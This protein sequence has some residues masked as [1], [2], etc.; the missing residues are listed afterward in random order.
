M[1]LD[2]AV[3][4]ASGGDPLLLYKIL[5]LLFFPL[6]RILCAL[7]LESR[8]NYQ[9][10]LD[11]GPLEFQFL[12]P[13][14]CLINPFRTLSLCFGVIDKTPG[15]TSSNNFV[16]KNFVCIGHHNNILA[17]C[18][19]IFPLLRWQGVWNKTCTQPSLSKSEE[20]LTWGSSKILLTF[21]MR[22]DGH[23]WKKSAT[24]TMFTSVLLNFGWATL[25]SSSTSSL[26]SRNREN[27]PKTFHRFTASFP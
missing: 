8:K 16:K 3:E 2:K 27:H 5:H 13:R 14:G 26:P 10:D 21:L 19:S 24:A 11:A 7:R 6:V 17:R 22:F 1:Q 4:C 25:S 9:H 20:L 18:D 15:L 23:F 12:L